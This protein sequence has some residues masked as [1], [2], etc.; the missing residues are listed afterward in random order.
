MKRNGLQALG[1]A[2]CLV[3]LMSLF[4]GAVPTIIDADW[5]TLGGAVEFTFQNGNDSVTQF[6]TMGGQMIG[7]LHAVDSDN[8]PY[9]YGVDN[10]LVEFKA[11]VLGGGVISSSTIRTDTKASSYG[12]AGQVVE[13]EVWSVD[14]R[15]YLAQ[16]V[17][18]NFA[19]MTI[20]NYGFQ[21]SDQFQAAGSLYGIL[22][23]IQTGDGDGV[24]FKAE[25][26]GSGI[27]TNMSNYLGG[28]SMT[29][30]EGLGCFEN[31][32]FVATGGGIYEL[33]AIAAHYMEGKGWEA[34]NGGV[35]YESLLFNDGAFIDDIDITGN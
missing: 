35:Y 5:D 15:A 24:E 22:H 6:I 21:S 4:A 10:G 3:A 1:I 31:S 29:W 8:D 11:E 25:G 33:T 14:G 34:P 27:L 2:S 23:S 18:T 20:P 19:A 16:R 17:V 9:N 28:A 7:S 26:S 13:S 12:P 32:D 30:G